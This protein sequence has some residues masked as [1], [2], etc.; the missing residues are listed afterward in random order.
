MGIFSFFKKHE[1][2]PNIFIDVGEHTSLA[3]KSGEIDYTLS[4]SLYASVPT[5]QSDFYEYAL[6][7]YATKT[8]ID[9]LSSFIG[10]PLI[11][12]SD[13]LFNID[14]NNFISNNKSALIKI[15]RQA[16]IDGVV[17][18]W[19]RIEKDIKEICQLI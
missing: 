7:N 15:Y 10:T 14:A 19:C 16:M 11:T 12:S 3:T 13:D 2:T 17:Y 1:P 8:Y 4:R 18:V 6:G 9:T 5:E